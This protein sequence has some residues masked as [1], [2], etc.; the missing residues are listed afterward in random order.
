MGS[1]LDI[2]FTS[3][4]KYNIQFHTVTPEDFNV[5]YVRDRDSIVYECDGKEGTLAFNGYFYVEAGPEDSNK[6]RRYPEC[7]PKKVFMSL[8]CDHTYEQY[9]IEIYKMELYESTNEISE[10]D[11][12]DGEEP[13]RVCF[14]PTN[15]MKIWFRILEDMN[16][17][18]S[19]KN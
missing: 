10:I 11:G 18:G 17:V 15:K 16:A 3:M 7:L 1:K 5:P 9:K 8:S 4:S 13:M 12:D 2:I 14:F 6:P 19:M